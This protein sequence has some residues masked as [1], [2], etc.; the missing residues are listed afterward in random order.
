MTGVP[1]YYIEPDW[2]AP[3]NVRA[4]VST[5]KG[6]VSKPPYDSFNLAQHVGDDPQRVVNNRA[7]LSQ[8]LALPGEPHWLQQ[9]H[10]TALLDLAGQDDNNEKDGSFTGTPNQICAVMTAD[11]LPVLMCTRAGDRVAAVHAGWRGLAAG[12]LQKAVA[13]MAIDGPELLA[14]LGPAIGPDKFEVGDD[15]YRE[16][17]ASSDA[18]RSAFV[19]AS[20]DHWHADLCQ[21]ARMQLRELGVDQVFGGTFCTFTDKDRFYSFRRDGVTGR[22][23]SLIWLHKAPGE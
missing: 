3:A 16:F 2:P 23:A 21:L 17:T 22:M 4:V 19:P 7:Q 5:R 14:W 10:G 18:A 6:G 12:I 9:V 13:A 8:D 11:C 1:P 20:A 15:V